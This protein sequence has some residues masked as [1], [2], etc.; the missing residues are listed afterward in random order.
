VINI[1]LAISQYAIILI[2]MFLM[3]CKYLK[4]K[5]KKIKARI[6]PAHAK[7]GD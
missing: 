6:S 5:L 4:V 3:R 7:A 2:I 1:F